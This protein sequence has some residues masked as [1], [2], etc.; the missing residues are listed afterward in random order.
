MP[1]KGSLSPRE[2]AK[3]PRRPR[4][5]ARS[6]G[7]K[8]EHIKYLWSLVGLY[9]VLYSPPYLISPEKSSF[10]QPGI[11]GLTISG[12]LSRLKHN[13]LTLDSPCFEQQ[14]KPRS[15]KA[16]TPTSQARRYS[17]SRARRAQSTFRPVQ[18]GEPG[19]PDREVV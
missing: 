12:R 10:S 2:D 5:G 14:P 18:L 11:T 4:K 6:L 1:Q 7:L 17:A 16:T 9:L 3:M 13:Y 15:K 19:G 8:V